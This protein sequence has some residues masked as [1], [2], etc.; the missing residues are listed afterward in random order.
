MLN[1]R[2]EIE[3]VMILDKIV[4]ATEKRV[5]DAKANLPLSELQQQ[6]ERMPITKDFPFEQAL[7]ELDFNFICEVKKA[8]P[9]KGII[10]EDF[11]YLEIAKEYEMAG[12]AAI[13]VLTEPDFFLGSPQY[14]QEIAEVVQITHSRYLE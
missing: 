8:S 4:A 7:Q 10:A 11:P 13:S 2:I 14:L 12:A 9:S 6:V 3:I 5:C 1:S